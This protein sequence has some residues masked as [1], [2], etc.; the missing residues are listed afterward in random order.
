ML[1]AAAEFR[2]SIADARQSGVLYDYLTT[3]VGPP[4]SYDDLLRFQIVFAVS[5]FD[6]LIHDLIRIGMRECFIGL[7]APTL[8]YQAETIGLEFHGLLAAQIEA[9]VTAALLNQPPPLP[10]KQFFF[11]QEIQRKLSLLTF[12]DPDRVAEGLSLIWAEKYKWDKISAQVGLPVQSVRTQLR[13][14]VTRRNGIVHEADNDPVLATKKP[15]T[16]Q[17]AIDSTDFIER[18]GS[19]IAHLVL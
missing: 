19:A 4:I 13:L 11:E 6:K 9:E 2:A 14:L 18:C 15:I 3:S 8:K 5:A 12:Q 1:N 16:R 7:R 10:P 17:I